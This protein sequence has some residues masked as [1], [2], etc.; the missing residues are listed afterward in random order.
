MADDLFYS[1]KWGNCSQARY[2]LME[3]CNGTAIAYNGFR[4]GSDAHNEV[5]FFEY[6]SLNLD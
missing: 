2:F 3:D 4:V 1:S 5:K 6:M